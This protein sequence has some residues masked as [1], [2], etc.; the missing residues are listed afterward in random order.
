MTTGEAFNVLGYPKLPTSSFADEIYETTRARGKASLYFFT[1]AVLG[2]NKVQVVPHLSL[3]NFIQSV[4]PPNKQRKVVLIPRDC[5]KSTVGSKSFPL[6]ILIQDSFC[7][8][9]GLEHRILLS[10]FSAENAKKQIKSL[11]QQIERNE[12]LRWLYPEIVPDV[13]STTWTDSN[14]LFPR[15]GSYGEDTI[16]AA[17]VDT[18][19]VSRHYT[20]QIKDDLEDLKSAES[21]TVR[22]RVK[23]FYRASEALFVDERSAY[24]LLIGTRW[25]ID[26]VYADIMLNEADSYEVQ[27]RPLHWTREELQYDLKTAEER[28]QPSIYAMD[29]DEYAP[30]PDKTYYFFPAL[31]PEESCKRIRAKQ[32]AWM[33]SMLYLNNPQDPSLAEFRERDLRYFVYDTEGNLKIENEEGVQEIVAFDM[34]KKV[35]FWDP[36][37]TALDER[38]GCKN[39]MVVA[40]KDRLG[41]IF[42]FEAAGEKK[43]P[44][45]LLTRYIGFHQRYLPAVSAIEDVGFQRIL[46][47]PLYHKMRELGHSFSVREERPI[48]EKDSRI[49]SLIPYT[50]SHLV[51]IRRGL[52]DLVDE[53]KGFPVSIQKDLLDATAACIP[54][55]GLYS[56]AP[57]VRNS[58]VEAQSLATRSKVTGY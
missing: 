16:E 58:R 55:F 4:E 15:Q 54:L 47:F 53:M 51:Y 29:P 44:T 31:F 48:G 32:G 5:Y 39:G 37:L 23:Q 14:L 24:D 49:R 22:E 36:A 34:I 43:D 30:E 21:P 50:E 52:R 12:L 10:S 3:C 9:P 38:K 8:L 7:G 1:T 20:V 40:G 11:R 33:Y 28:N 42:V 6:W 56:V 18:H 57:A 17:G 45:L 46:K 27:V 26:D 41:R 35:L 13:G 19:I 25:G 2:W